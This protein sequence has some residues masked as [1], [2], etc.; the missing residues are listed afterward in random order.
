MLRIVVPGSYPE[1]ARRRR[2][3]SVM[4]WTMVATATLALVVLL[5]ADVLGSAGDRQEVRGLYVAILLAILGART[6]H[7]LNRFVSGE[8]AGILFVAL[9]LVV[10]VFADVPMQV[11]AGR[12]LFTFAIPIVAASVI[13]PSWMSFVT[14][15][16]SSLVVIVMTLTATHTVLNVPAVLGFFVLALVS[17]LGARS[18]EHALQHIEVANAA[19]RESEETARALLKA[20]TDAA[21]LLDRQGITLDAN[22]TMA[23]RLRSHVDALVGTCMWDLLPTDVAARRK[24]TIEQVVRSAQP[25]RFEDEWQGT[26]NDNVIYPI[27]DEKARVTRI[28]MLSRDIT[29]RRETEHRV[30]RLLGQQMTINELA[31]AL[32]NTSDVE[33]VYHTIYEHVRALMDAEAFIV[34]F[35]ERETRLIHAGYVVSNGNVLDVARFPP[36]PL[37]AEG[38]GTQSRVIHAGAPIHIP[39]Y[40]KAMEQTQTEYTIHE[41]K[42]VTQGPPPPQ[43]REESTKSLLCVPIKIE[44]QTIGVMQVQSYRLDA[45]TQEDIDMLAG[46]A[47]VA[48]VAIRNARLL[49]SL[50]QSN[51]ELAE[52]HD[53]LEELVAERTSELRTMVNLMAGREVRMAE[54]KGAIRRLRAQLEE[55]GLEPVADD[56]L[57]GGL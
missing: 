4:L 5:V 46:L 52:H 21:A 16:L 36:I 56:P 3:L 9:W 23:H 1:G 11:V 28:A 55:A 2:L 49:E 14:A 40:R 19:V 25:I 45:Y 20:P 32:G 18:L 34:S 10:A 57:L 39:D 15:G 24:A 29:E 47:N 33:S 54:L 43:A 37:E 22:E 44:G 6:L 8:L 27:L 26:W 17:H 12:G 30:Q 48:T 41:G 13:L 53:H 31:L 35:Y 51:Q 50:Q 42:T 7:A 38:H